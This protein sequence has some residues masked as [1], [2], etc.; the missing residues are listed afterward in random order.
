MGAFALGI[1]LVIGLMLSSAAVYAWM[2]AGSRHVAAEPV[3]LVD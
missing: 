2:E 1:W 3:P